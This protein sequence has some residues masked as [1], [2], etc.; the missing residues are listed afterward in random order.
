[1]VSDALL[2]AVCLGAALC[3]IWRGAWFLYQRIS[4]TGIQQAEAV[5]IV[6]ERQDDV[7]M[8]WLLFRAGEFCRVSVNEAPSTTP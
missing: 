1:M 6:P 3:R 2:L 7:K 4:S 8:F 5:R